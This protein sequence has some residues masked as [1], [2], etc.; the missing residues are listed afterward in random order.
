MDGSEAVFRRREGQWGNPP[1]LL[2]LR[3]HWLPTSWSH[4][5]DFTRTSHHKYTETFLEEWPS[6]M[7]GVVGLFGIMSHPPPWRF[8]LKLGREEENWTHVVLPR[9]AIR[10]LFG[11]TA[12]GCMRTTKLTVVVE[13]PLSSLFAHYIVFDQYF[14]KGGRRALVDIFPQRYRGNQLAQILQP[15]EGIGRCCRRRRYDIVVV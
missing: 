15:L 8:C 10:D 3:S 9:G 1:P 11:T 6:C 4:C 14:W 12:L 2:L 13:K 7:M 5:M